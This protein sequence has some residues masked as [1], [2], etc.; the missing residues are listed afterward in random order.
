MNHISYDTFH[1]IVTKAFAK[2][3]SVDCGGGRHPSFGLQDTD[4][5]YGAVVCDQ[6]EYNQ[7]IANNQPPA[8]AST[9]LFRTTDW[10]PSY[11]GVIALTTLTI[12]K[13]DGQILDADVEV[14]GTA[15]PVTGGP[16]ITTS[17]TS[18]GDEKSLDAIVTHE[19][20][21]FLGLAH[22]LNRDATMFYAYSD[23]TETLERD[24]VTGI[25]TVYPGTSK[26]AC[27][28]PAPLSGF[29][30]YCGGVNPSTSPYPRANAGAGCSIGPSERSTST[31]WLVAP[32]VLGL[33]AARRR[34]SRT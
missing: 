8:N 17:E 24:D 16:Q 28:E 15:S 2:W 10:P 33:A 18:I 27:E 30:R 21:H 14:D 7:Q 19:S 34:R 11:S 6:H 31:W 1:S 26:P 3:A 4:E 20:G 32:A 22:S 23:G 12:D 13:R 25:C 5:L 9:W 29:S